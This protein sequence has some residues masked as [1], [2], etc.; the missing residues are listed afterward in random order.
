MPDPSSLMSRLSRLVPA[1][2][3]RLRIEPTA[4]GNARRELV[5]WNA[6]LLRAGLTAEAYDSLPPGWEVLAEAT[7]PETVGRHP[8]HRDE[9]V[10]VYTQLAR[11]MDGPDA[12]RWL[13][14]AGLAPV[15]LNRDVVAAHESY[16]G[17]QALVLARLDDADHDPYG[18]WAVAAAMTT[19]YAPER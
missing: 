11:P 9:D 2:F 15:M 18:F 6:A 7:G 12:G 5:H 14:V 3:T 10:A 8:E 13:L 17:L 16:T 1:R 4:Y 19:R